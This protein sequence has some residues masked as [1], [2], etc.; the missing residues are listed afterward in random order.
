MRQRKEIKLGNEDK[1]GQKGNKQKINKR[2]A[3]SK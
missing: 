2:N 3:K 1:D